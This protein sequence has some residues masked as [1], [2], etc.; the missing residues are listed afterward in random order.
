MSD[1]RPSHLWG[2]GDECTSL[3]QN[4]LLDNECLQMKGHCSPLRTMPGVGAHRPPRIHEEKIPDP[5]RCDDLDVS[6]KRL[7]RVVP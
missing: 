3:A 7:S 1:V 2:D 6:V 4:R 5:F